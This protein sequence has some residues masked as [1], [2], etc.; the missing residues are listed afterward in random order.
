MYLFDDNGNISIIGKQT[1]SISFWLVIT[2]IVIVIT[3]IVIVLLN[4]RNR[5]RNDYLP[6]N[7]NNSEFSPIT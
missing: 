6:L 2:I 7:P 1:Q 4:L 3:T 5:N